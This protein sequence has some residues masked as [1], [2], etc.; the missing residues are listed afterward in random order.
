MRVNV[1]VAD[2]KKQ[3]E[4]KLPKKLVA[5]S[6]RFVQLVIA[7]LLVLMPPTVASSTVLLRSIPIFRLSVKAKV[8]N[9]I[10]SLLRR[11]HSS[12]NYDAARQGR[13]RAFVQLFV[14]TNIFYLTISARH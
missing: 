11:V 2:Y 14:A 9:V 7:I 10:L 8:A 1:D 12:I 13:R 4:E 6:R 3:R 5:G